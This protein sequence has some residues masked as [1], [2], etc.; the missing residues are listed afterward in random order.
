MTSLELNDFP[1]W[2]T[3]NLGPRSIRFMP[4]IRGHW[5]SSLDHSLAIIL[6]LILAWGILDLIFG[7][8]Y[9][10]GK[11]YSLSLNNEKNE[12]NSL[13]SSISLANGAEMPMMG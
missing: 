10:S 5:L 4:Q 7:L 6:V 13:D 9:C 8:S 3:V 2:T 1:H 11:F 12:G